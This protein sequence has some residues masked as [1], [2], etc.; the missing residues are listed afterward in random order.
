MTEHN[1]SELNPDLNRI[2]DSGINISTI[3]AGAAPSSDYDIAMAE[4][5]AISDLDL[6]ADNQSHRRDQRW[7]NEFNN[8]L[9]YV[10]RFLVLLFILMIF[11]LVAHW[12]LPEKCHWLNEVQ[13][14]QIKTIIAA[15]FASKVISDQQGKLK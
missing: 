11:A 13:L 12:I 9:I 6:D 8:A 5:R 4:S 7:K 1:N 3:E 15:A 10:F 2:I 14:D